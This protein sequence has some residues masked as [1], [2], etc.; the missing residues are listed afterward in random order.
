MYFDSRHIAVL[1]GTVAAVAAGLY[2]LWGP[3]GSTRKPRLKGKTNY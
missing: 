3:S 2:V 1:G